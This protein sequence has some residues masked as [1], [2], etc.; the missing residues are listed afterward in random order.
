MAVAQ[1]G[2]HKH[3]AYI[4][5][6]ADMP[7]FSKMEQAHL[8]LLVLAHR[9]SL[10]KLRGMVAKDADWTLLVALRLAA[11]V[12]PHALAHAQQYPG[13]PVRMIYDRHEDIAATTKRHPALVRHRTGIAADGSRT[14]NSDG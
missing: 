14:P 4:L 6:N 12:L 10:D 8:S 2:F 7:G 3:S 1:A 13:R 9:G 11:L 5:T